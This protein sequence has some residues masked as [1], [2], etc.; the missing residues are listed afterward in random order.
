M[1]MRLEG[2]FQW[3]QSM[4][5]G[6][7]KSVSFLL[8]CHRW[9]RGEKFIYTI[10][11][12][13]GQI[14][15]RQSYQEL[16]AQDSIRFDYDTIGWDWCNGDTF[17]VLDSKGKVKEHWTLNLRTYAP[18]E[19][20]D[21]HGTHLCPTCRGKGQ[22]TDSMHMIYTCPTC[23]G[24]GQCQRCYIPTRAAA[25]PLDTSSL[26]NDT[27][28][29]VNTSRQQRIAALR[30]YIADLQNKIDHCELD[31]RMDKWDRTLHPDRTADRSFGTYLAKQQMKQQFYNQLIAAQNELQQL[32]S[33]F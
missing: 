33:M 2:E 24:T 25:T 1:S 30:R 9:F 28:H 27:N 6:G 12:G 7:R 17:A 29:S 8:T 3:Y 31:D 20:P 10:Y 14:P 18:G 15:P 5:K 32:E 13:N 22:V 11:D 21:C 16:P 19:C 23:G 26:A 4:R